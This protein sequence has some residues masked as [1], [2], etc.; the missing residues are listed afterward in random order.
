MSPLQRATKERAKVLKD[1]KKTK[2]GQKTNP[3]EVGVYGFIRV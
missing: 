2:K 3:T 1:K